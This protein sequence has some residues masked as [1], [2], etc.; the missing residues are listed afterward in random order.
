[1]KH[2]VLLFCMKNAKQVVCLA[3]RDVSSNTPN[4]MQVSAVN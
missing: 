2:C 4:L 1:M 3:T